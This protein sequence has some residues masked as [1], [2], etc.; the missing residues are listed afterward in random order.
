[1]GAYVI[2]VLF[3]KKKGNNFELSPLN[4][5]SDPQTLNVLRYINSRLCLTNNKQ[6]YEKEIVFFL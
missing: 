4:G 6:C 5:V 3:S 1:M 2:S